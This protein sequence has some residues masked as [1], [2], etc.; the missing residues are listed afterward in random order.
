MNR[1]LVTELKAM[2]KEK[3]GRK[4]TVRRSGSVLI[5]LDIVNLK[6]KI[7]GHEQ[8]F[9][10]CKAAKPSNTVDGGFAVHEAE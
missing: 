10:D 8:G 2:Q 5:T 7:Q 6:S 9:K 1:R 3:D 4:R